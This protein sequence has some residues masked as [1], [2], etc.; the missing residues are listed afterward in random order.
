MAGALVGRLGTQKTF[1]FNPLPTVSSR[2]TS[3]V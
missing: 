2:F 3:A 1:G